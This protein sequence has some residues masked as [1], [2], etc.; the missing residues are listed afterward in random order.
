M[1][2]EN[3][4]EFFYIKA[5]KRI[6]REV[7]KSK[8]PHQKIHMRDSKQISWIINNKRTKNNRFLITDA[9]IDNCDSFGNPDGLL[10]K[11]S[12]KNRKEI[13]WGADKEIESYLPELFKLLWDEIVS[14]DSFYNIDKE[15]FLCDYIPYAKYRTFGNI[16]FSQDNAYPAIMY[17]IY[18]DDI[19]EKNDYVEKDAF[20][21]LYNRCKHD[22]SNIFFEFANE[23]DSF[24]KINHYFQKSFI[25]KL[26]IPMLV[27]YKPNGNSLG[28]RTKSLIESDLSH[29]A[30]LVCKDNNESN[31]YLSKLINA[32]SI[33]IMALDEVQKTKYHQRVKG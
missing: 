32:S 27:R 10:H 23:R 19:I 29:C 33:Y 31:N 25:E 1:D 18:E 8:L 24:H 13:L 20:I 22:F 12:F 14:E 28:L 16:I 17:G 15:L 5:S 4:M 21:Y 6:K 7:E 2:I 3:I 26:F 11:L 9:I 30:S